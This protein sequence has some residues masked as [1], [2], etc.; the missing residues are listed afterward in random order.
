[1]NV[2]LRWIAIQLVRLR[3]VGH[4][5][6]RPAVLIVID[7]RDASA[8]ELGSKMPQVAVTSSNVP[9]P[10]CGTASRC[11]R[12][13]LGRAVRLLLAVELQNTSCLGDHL[14]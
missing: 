5:D 12:D 6:V 8:F 13:T 3:V 1:V 10:R 2:P 7:Q 11:R 9:L 4:E 14:T